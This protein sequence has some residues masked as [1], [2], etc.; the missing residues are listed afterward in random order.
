MNSELYNRK[1]NI[2]PDILNKI[3]VAITNTNG[4][5]G[6]KRAKYL[7]K[8]GQITYQNLKRLKNFFDHFNTQSGDRNQYEL[9]GGDLMRNFI[10]QTL[11]RE[12]DSVSRSKEIK[13]DINID[14]NLGNKAQKTPKL[15][16][17][18][19]ND[20]KKNAL[21]III[22]ENN[23]ILLLRRSPNIEAWQ[24][25]K[26]ALVGGGVEEGEE[27]VDT[28]K[29]E[30]YEETGLRINNFKEKFK[31]Q[32][33]PDSVEYVFIAKYDGDPHDIKLNFEHINYGWYSPEEII[34]LNHVPNLLDYINLAFKKYD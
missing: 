27:P 10:E 8:N 23:K 15:N 12:R 7:V 9:A 32:R 17:D 14:P 28:C 33:N 24:P 13:R 26:W 34:F 19:D 22:N 11:N 5:N 3:Q 30:I 18:I 25:G 16:E 21:A 4:S 29:R 1:F 2:P 6:V 20:L 31:L